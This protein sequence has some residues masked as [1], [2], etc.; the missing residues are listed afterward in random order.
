[1]NGGAGEGGWGWGDS[2]LAKRFYICM[3]FTTPVARIPHTISAGGSME[4]KNG[5][6]KQRSTVGWRFWMHACM[7]AHAAGHTDQR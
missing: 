5:L 3:T 6:N 4:E 1:M 7:R 2:V